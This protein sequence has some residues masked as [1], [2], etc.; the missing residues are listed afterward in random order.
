M[1]LTIKSS[2]GLVVAV[3]AAAALVSV[4][5]PAAAAPQ[6]ACLSMW[7]TADVDA[8]G[9][10]TQA[11][12]KAGYI[13]AAKQA[14]RE[15]ADPPVIS[16][17]EFVALCGEDVFAG[18]AGGNK[19]VAAPGPASSQDLGKGDITPSTKALS[20]AD[21][22]KKLTASGFREIEDLALDQG[23]VW[24]GTAV[25]NGQR[26]DVAIDGQGDIVAEGKPADADAA[27]QA[28]MPKA[29]TAKQ[30]SESAEAKPQPVVSRGSSGSGALPVWVFL[31]VGNALALVIL[32][33]MTAGGSS[34]MA[35]RTTP[36]PFV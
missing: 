31:L 8:N 5:N 20:E 30:K 29:D 21:A 19:A 36:A 24:R 15:L 26:Q 32:S 28:A 18:L 4:G 17:D 7:K 22:K 9:A 25:A 3:V 6:E 10:L 34:A 13:A 12:D 11:E 27:Q 23:G 14:G 2:N 35:T 1:S 33:A 16:R